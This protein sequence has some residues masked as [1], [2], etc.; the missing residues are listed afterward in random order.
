MEAL[1]LFTYG[2]TYVQRTGWQHFQNLATTGHTHALRVG[3]CVCHIWATSKWIQFTKRF[4]EQPK[5]LYVVSRVKHL[6]DHTCDRNRACFSTWKC[7]QVYHS[8]PIWNS[9]YTFIWPSRN[10]CPIT[11]QILSHQNTPS[12]THPGPWGVH[13][14]DHE[15]WAKITSFC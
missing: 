11:S 6:Q 10:S 7:I 5:G 4:H 15:V 12:H 1:C 2:H 13:K 8:M 14:P 3:A 9:V